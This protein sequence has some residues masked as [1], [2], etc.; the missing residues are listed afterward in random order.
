MPSKNSH[1]LRVGAMKNS[2]K[3]A[4]TGGI[5][6]GKSIVARILKTMGYPVYDC[7][8]EARRIMSDD[9]DIHRFLVEEI[10][11]KAVV[12]GLIDRKVVA[13]VVFNN[14]DKLQRLNGEIH[15]RVKEDFADYVEKSNS[16]VVFVETAILFSSDMHNM[17]DFIIDVTADMPTRIERIAM[18]NNLSESEIIERIE[19]QSDEM[20]TKE[21]YCRDARG[22]PFV[23]IDNS[24]SQAILPQIEEILRRLRNYL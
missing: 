15:Y 10:S 1:T 8:S 2:L 17:V 12:N 11:P 21:L 22:V 7:D 6:S 18:R 14:P 9:K 5:G 23:V 4:I 3:V 24:G 16:P 20:T 13:D 19:A